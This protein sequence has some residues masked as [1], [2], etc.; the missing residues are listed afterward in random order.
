MALLTLTC[1]VTG[2]HSTHLGE[3]SPV[4]VILPLRPLLQFWQLLETA[5]SIPSA[6]RLGPL[7]SC[8]EGP[9]PALGSSG[10]PAILLSQ[11]GGFT[12][13]PPQTEHDKKKAGGSPA[14]GLPASQGSPGDGLGSMA[15][16][17]GPSVACPRRRAPMEGHPMGG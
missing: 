15:S 10:K 5:Q 3:D 14:W 1:P 13:S 12:L 2:T 17:P 16:L 11:G 4:V 7:L 9:Y 6:K 8:L